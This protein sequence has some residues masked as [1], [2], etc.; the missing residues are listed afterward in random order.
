VSDGDDH[1]SD[2]Q[3][4]YEESLA[5]SHSA[6]RR[7][8]WPF[9]IPSVALGLVLTNIFGLWALL[10][11]VALFLV[12]IPLLASRQRFESTSSRREREH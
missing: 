12:I 10:A 2:W 4:R 5:N 3:Q 7:R 9:A 1:R 8:V 6:D 11:A